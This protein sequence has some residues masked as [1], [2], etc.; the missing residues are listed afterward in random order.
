MNHGYA[1]DKVSTLDVISRSAKLSRAASLG[2]ATA[3]AR[4]RTSDGNDV[5][6]MFEK[7]LEDNV[8]TIGVGM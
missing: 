6:E 2:S 1:D 5:T 3:A 4:Y 8:T 7:A